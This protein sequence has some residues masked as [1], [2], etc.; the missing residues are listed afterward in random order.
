MTTSASDSSPHTSEQVVWSGKPWIFP[1][2]I[3]DTILV[4]VLA[5]VIA[6]IELATG[7]AFSQL[8]GM[9]IVLW[10]GLVLFVLWIILM[11]RLLL[12]RAA[13]SYL[14]RKDSLEVRMGILS[15]N[16]FVTV[17]SGFSD[18]Q[19]KISVVGR[20]IN[21]GDIVINA[22]SE[23]EVCMKMVRRPQSVAAQIREI[24]S[25]PI[26]RIEEHDRV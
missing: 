3:V 19:V 2:A 9:A 12:V 24:M 22:Q 6:W 23:H 11:I 14:L 5:V 25:K 1:S 17:P 10:T 13:N 18:L 16:T 26:V 15:T 4:I 8:R 7:V 21:S 20:M